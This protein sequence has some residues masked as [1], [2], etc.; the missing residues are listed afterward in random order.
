MQIEPDTKIVQTH[1]GSQTSLEA[2]QVVRTLPSQAKGVQEF[3][4]D[5][6]DDL[7]NPCQPAA[8][9]LG[10]AD[11]FTGL[12]RRSDQIDLRLLVPSLAWS[13]SGKALVSHIGALGRQAGAGQTR[14]WHLPSAKQGFSQV[15]IMGAGRTK[16]KTSNDA[17]GID[18]QQ[19]MKA[20]IP[21]QPITPANI[22]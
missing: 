21:S 14:R 17:D 7:P 3:V 10:P 22:R 4:I 9:R 1:F 20:F 2:C 19:Q 6:F 15:L 5:R 8:Q 16:A 11:P 18:G 12:M 13:L